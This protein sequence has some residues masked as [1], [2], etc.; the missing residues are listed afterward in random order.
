MG[1]LDDARATARREAVK[2]RHDAVERRDD[3]QD[4]LRVD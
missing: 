2:H 3:A 1:I 4:H